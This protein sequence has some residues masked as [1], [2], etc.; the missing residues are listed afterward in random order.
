MVVTEGDAD[1]VGTQVS[2]ASGSTAAADSDMSPDLNEQSLR[3]LR[4]LKFDPRK[5]EESGPSVGGTPASAENVSAG[6]SD[7]DLT[8]QPCSYSDVRLNSRAQSSHGD[9]AAAAADGLSTRASWKKAEV[10]GGFA[11]QLPHGAAGPAPPQS[12]AEVQAEAKAKMWTWMS[13]NFP[14]APPHALKGKGKGKRP[15]T[16]DSGSPAMTT[17]VEPVPKP[18]TATSA[19]QHPPAAGS[20]GSNWTQTSGPWNAES[21]REWREQRSGRGWQDDAERPAAKRGS[22]PYRAW[23]PGPPKGKKGRKGYDQGS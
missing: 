21:D 12:E 18:S 23:A 3:L 8:A 2:G 5:T 4:Q 10:P 19:W 16:I 9:E 14:A 7:V 11:M 1:F 15:F 22:A 17:P 6:S 20:K 13:N